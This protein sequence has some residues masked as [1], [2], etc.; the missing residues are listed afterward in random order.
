MK[1]IDEMVNTAAIDTSKTCGEVWDMRK[2]SKE[3][4]GGTTPSDHEIWEWAKATRQR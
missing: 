3:G 4:E 2:S 1:E